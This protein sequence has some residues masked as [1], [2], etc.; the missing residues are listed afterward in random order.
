[1]NHVTEANLSHDVS[2]FF[3]ENSRA[4][5]SLKRETNLKMGRP[6]QPEPQPHRITPY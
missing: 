3:V 1:M 5:F 6:A 2:F 4:G